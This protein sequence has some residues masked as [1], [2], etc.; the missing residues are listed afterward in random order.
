MRGRGKRLTGQENS[1]QSGEREKN[2]LYTGTCFCASWT[3]KREKGGGE[4]KGR[5]VLSVSGGGR[6]RE[7]QLVVHNA[8]SV[9]AQDS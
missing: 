4:R 3:G 2:C 5:A 8:W 1:F 7:E 9:F 6:G